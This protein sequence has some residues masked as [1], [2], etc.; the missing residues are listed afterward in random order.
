MPGL[1]LKVMVWNVNSFSPKANQKVKDIISENNPQ[2]IFLMETWKETNFKN[3]GYHQISINNNS[4]RDTLL[5]RTDLSFTYEISENSISLKLSNHKFLF[6]YFNPNPKKLVNPL[7]NSSLTHDFIFADFNLKTYLRSKYKNNTTT[8]L[9]FF[10]IHYLDK[11]SQQGMISKTNIIYQYHTINNQQTS[12]HEVLIYDLDII[13]DYIIKTTNNPH[14]PEKWHPNPTFTKPYEYK[15]IFRDFSDI[16]Q[17]YSLMKS[18][19]ITL[20]HLDEAT[21]NQFVSCFKQE[22]AP[23]PSRFDSME[24]QIN[25]CQTD[26]IFKTMIHDYN[27]LNWAE[28]NQLTL[29]LTRG[30]QTVDIYGLSTKSFIKKGVLD[31]KQIMNAAIINKCHRIIYVVKDRHRKVEFTNLRPITIIPAALKIIE[32]LFLHFYRDDLEYPIKFGTINQYAF[33]S[34][35]NVGQAINRIQIQEPKIIYFIDL[36]KAYDCLNHRTMIS[37]ISHYYKGDL[38]KFLQKLSWLGVHSQFLLNGDIFS[39]TKGTSQ[40]GTLSPM[41]FNIYLNYLLKD[42]PE[43]I[44][45]K[46][47][48]FADDIAAVDMNHEELDKLQI[49]L[50]N[51]GFYINLEKSECLTSELNLENPE[52]T[53]WSDITKTNKVTYLGFYL[54][55][56]IKLNKKKKKDDEL[57]PIEYEL[58]T[59]IPSINNLGIPKKIFNYLSPHMK[60]TILNCYTGSKISYHLQNPSTRNKT[61]DIQR[62]LQSIKFIIGVQH[63]G[64]K[65]IKFIHGL[66]KDPIFDKFSTQD[67]GGSWPL[68]FFKYKF[69]K[70]EGTFLPKLKHAF[71]L[72]FKTDNQNNYY[73]IK[74][75]QKHIPYLLHKCYINELEYKTKRILPYYLFLEEIAYHFYQIQN[76]KNLDEMTELLIKIIK[77]S[78]SFLPY[79]D[80]PKRIFSILCH[81]SKIITFNKKCSIIKQ[82]MTAKEKY[83]DHPNNPNH[84]VTENHILMRPSLTQIVLRYALGLPIPKKFR[85]SGISALAA[86]GYF[87]DSPL[88]ESKMN[89][90]ASA[91]ENEG[92]RNLYSINEQNPLE[93]DIMKED[94]E[95]EMDIDPDEGDFEQIKSYDLM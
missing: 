31:L 75:T 44:I 14:H 34:G 6:T 39:R 93:E 43:S 80:Q 50:N 33:L 37:A 27:K 91:I 41:I 45:K 48:L 74:N 12:D 7:Q 11:L 72:L 68:E 92:G 5:I 3:L 71:L 56:R 21:K 36:K 38:G 22:G 17:I 4:S 89:I 9:N 46:L 65:D 15:Q 77:E 84:K 13:P 28:K 83:L 67:S 60:L 35:K 70:K 55:Y 18:T 20:A 69:N 54:S 16:K 76:T 79:N 40:G 49:A 52:F 82:S 88:V 23:F 73:R 47:T 2:I 29:K 78:V 81:Q 51:G 86:A 61:L 24:Q 58:F 10:P 19:D 64:Y 8:M 87:G 66:Q 42:L 25:L 90:L 57:N 85:Y 53:T 94:N 62:Y 1:S 30:S 59:K 95:L 63:V 32:R 26:K